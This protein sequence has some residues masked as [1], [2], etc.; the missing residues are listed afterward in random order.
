MK[1]I[2]AVIL[3]IVIIVAFWLILPSH[4]VRPIAKPSPIIKVQPSDDESLCDPISI[5]A[6]ENPDA[7]W[8][9]CRDQDWD[10]STFLKDRM[11]EMKE[12]PE[13]YGALC[14]SDDVQRIILPSQMTTERATPKY[15]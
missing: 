1:S 15:Q 12:K 5:L 4:P 10:G 8:S 11:A 7:R 13:Q 6:A 2:I 14:Q 3:A 9:H